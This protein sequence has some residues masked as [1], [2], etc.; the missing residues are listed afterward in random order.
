MVTTFTL[1]TGA[2]SPASPNSAASLIA[3]CNSAFQ[4]NFN[5]GGTVGG[6]LGLAPAGC[7][8]PNLNDV[9]SQLRNPKYV[10]WNFEA[11]HRLNSKTVVSANYVGNK[12]YDEL[13]Q[14]P[15][16]NAFG[17]GGLPTTPIDTRVKS[18]TQLQNTGVSNYN[19]I[20]VSLQEQVTH[21]LSGR[22]NYTYAHALDDISNG[23]IL[24]Y[25]L[26]N[27]IIHQI[28]PF[29]LRSLNY[30]N[31]DYDLRHSLSASYVWDLPFKAGN[32]LLNKAVGG[33]E[34][35]G[36]FFYHTGFPFSVIDGTS[37]LANQGK[38]MQFITVLGLPTTTVPRQY[39]SSAVTTPCF[40]TSQFVPAGAA[41]TFGT[42]PR[43]SF[44]GP[45]YFNTD[46]S[47]RKNFVVREHYGFMIGANAYNILN[48]VNFA[49]PVANLNAGSSFGTILS[50]VNPPTSPY[51]SFAAAA[52]DARIVQVIAKLTF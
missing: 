45:G 41:T 48:H 44:R 7:Q 34:V 5:N 17:F 9:V 11:E 12:G 42:I 27:S 51:G 35:S 13:V 15:Y 49:N 23:G 19:G 47:L 16:L 4:S 26:S 46:L 3:A 38:N 22:F 18:V 40:T 8:P 24:P 50:T 2:V 29:S 21:G 37:M 36:T 1:T 43:N 25:S 10:E 31:A 6:F 28:S 14:F 39:S 30:S 52:V 32:S 33:W 20:T